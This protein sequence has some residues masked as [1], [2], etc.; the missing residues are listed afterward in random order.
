MRVCPNDQTPLVP[1]Y[2][3]EDH[4]VKLE[5]CPQCRGVWAD[6]SS[7]QGLGAHFHRVGVDPS[8]QYGN[9]TPS[10]GVGSTFRSNLPGNLSPEA[11]IALAQMEM[12]HEEFMAKANAFSSFFGLLGI[13]RYHYWWGNGM[14]W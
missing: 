10:Y 9:V 3:A 11:Q 6:H 1:F 5:T 7:L 2:Y 8:G 14:G 12:Q 13:S 4:S